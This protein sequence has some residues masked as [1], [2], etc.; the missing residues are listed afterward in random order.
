MRRE[1]SNQA[2]TDVM[3]QGHLHALLLINFVTC[4]PESHSQHCNSAGVV[5]HGLNVFW[6][7]IPE[8]A[9]PLYVFNQSTE[10][11]KF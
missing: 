3:N 6:R 4:I 9:C 5:S 2:F 10:T 8:P 7:Q 1:V 11:G